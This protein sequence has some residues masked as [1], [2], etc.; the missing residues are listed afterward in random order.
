[1]SFSIRSAKGID[2]IFVDD[3]L[4]GEPLRIHISVLAPGD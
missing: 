1:M 3:H 4:E 2:K